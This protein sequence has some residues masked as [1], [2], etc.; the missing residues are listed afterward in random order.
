[1][2]GWP[3]VQSYVP[4]NQH[5]SLLNLSF[6]VG[7][8]PSVFPPHAYCAH[9]KCS[10]RASFY[11]IPYSYRLPPM[12]LS[13]DHLQYEAITASIVKIE[14][15]SLSWPHVK[16]KS[17]LFMNYLICENCE[18]FFTRDILILWLRLIFCKKIDTCMK[19]WNLL[20]PQQQKSCFLFFLHT[21]DFAW[22]KKMF[23]KNNSGG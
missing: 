21:R 17:K 14:I 6:R 5:N 1:M 11:C 19:K 10:A 20:I 3:L 22:E 7:R 23:H 18:R 9:H 15:W 4:K 16:K 13:L 8:P 2:C 12:L